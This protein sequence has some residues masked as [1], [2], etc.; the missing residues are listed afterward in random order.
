[1]I[2]CAP[3]GFAASAPLVTFVMLLV[4]DRASCNMEIVLDASMRK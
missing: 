1:M 3:E 4:I 2:S